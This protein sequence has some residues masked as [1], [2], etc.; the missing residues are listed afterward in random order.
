MAGTSGSGKTTLARRLADVLD[1]PHIEID[2]LFHGPD[3]T[4]REGFVRDVDAFSRSAAWVTEWQYKVVRELLAD[5]CDLAVWLDLPRFTVMHQ[6]IHRTLRRRLRR[7]VLW[8]G[9]VES[10]FWT[11]FTNRD[12]IIRWAWSTHHR[13]AERV[14]RLAAERPELPIVRLRSHADADRWLAGPV[15]RSTSRIID[16]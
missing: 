13:S 8:N 2:A 10:S 15:M 14:R 12:H 4:P 3:W 11:L 1:A 5:R 7:E 9:N 6:I 16:S